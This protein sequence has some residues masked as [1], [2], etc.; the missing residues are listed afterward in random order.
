LKI[1]KNLFQLKN[2]LESSLKSSERRALLL[3]KYSVFNKKLVKKLLVNI[4]EYHY[5]L[6]QESKTIILKIQDYNLIRKRTL[7]STMTRIVRR[8]RMKKRRSQK[9]KRKDLHIRNLG[10]WNKKK[11]RIWKKLRNKKRKWQIEI[12][13][14]LGED[15]FHI[16]FKIVKVKTIVIV[17]N[18][19]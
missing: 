8:K 7:M 1:A 14:V 15:L 17:M 6:V 19:L 16:R 11:W 13:I 2:R 9:L 12:V 18:F 5:R 4:D 10:R 3:P